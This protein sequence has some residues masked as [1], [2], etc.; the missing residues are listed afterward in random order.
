MAFKMMYRPET[1]LK[2]VVN[3]CDLIFKMVTCMNF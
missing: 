2:Y 1:L 3:V